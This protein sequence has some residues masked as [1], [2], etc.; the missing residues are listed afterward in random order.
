MRQTVSAM[1][2]PNS[3]SVYFC[4]GPLSPSSNLKRTINKELSWVYLD[5]VSYSYL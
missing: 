5:L 2:S 3:V 1:C 4:K